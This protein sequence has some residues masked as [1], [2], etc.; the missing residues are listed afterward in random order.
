[1][2]Q[3]AGTGCHR[4]AQRGYRVSDDTGGVDDARLTPGEMQLLFEGL[5][6]YVAFVSV[7]IRLG[8]RANPPVIPGRPS[9]ADVDSAFS[10]LETMTQRGLVKVGHLEHLDGGPPDCQLHL[11]VDP[12]QEVRR[13]VLHACESGSDWESSCW[14]VNTPLGCDLALKAL[15]ES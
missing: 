13:L 10:A 1:M 3:F 14:V 11:V 12:L 2:S 5:T 7:L 6:E 15:A 4:G 8:I 9:V